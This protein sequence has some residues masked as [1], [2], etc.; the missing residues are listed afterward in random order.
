MVIMHQKLTCTGF[1]FLTRFYM[2]QS[3]F[4]L[5]IKMQKNIIINASKKQKQKIFVEIITVDCGGFIVK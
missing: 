1:K 2:K 5:T 3:I 4:K